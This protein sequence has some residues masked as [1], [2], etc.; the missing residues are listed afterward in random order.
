MEQIEVLVELR[1]SKKLTQKEL[2]AALGI[3]M[4]TFVRYERCGVIPRLDFY[5]KW[6]SYLNN[7]GEREF[8]GGCGFRPADLSRET[9]Y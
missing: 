8:K 5:L 2:S 6:Q 9:G 4:S 1:R 3:P 7:Y